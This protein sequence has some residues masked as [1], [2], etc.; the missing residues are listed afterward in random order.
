ML[1]LYSNGIFQGASFPIQKDLNLTQEEFDSA[2]KD[3]I[4]ITQDLTVNNQIQQV[5]V[6]VF[7]RALHR[8]GS[9]TI[10]IR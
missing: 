4:L 5:R 1:A 8:M 9:V 6:M 3:G 2:S 10:P 7:D